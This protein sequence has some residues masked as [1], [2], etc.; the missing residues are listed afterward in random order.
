MSE[1][2]LKVESGGYAAKPPKPPTPSV[3]KALGYA[4]ESLARLIIIGLAVFCLIASFILAMKYRS[5]Y[6]REILM[7]IGSTL[8]YLAGKDFDKKE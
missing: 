7:V 4:R 2:G 6:A 1:T 8:G 5:E 3:I